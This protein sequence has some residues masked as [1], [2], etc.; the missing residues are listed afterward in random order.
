MQK[1]LLGSNLMSKHNDLSENESKGNWASLN[2]TNIFCFHWEDLIWG[3]NFSILLNKLSK[4]RIKFTLISDFSSLRIFYPSRVLA[5]SYKWLKWAQVINF[6]MVDNLTLQEW[7]NFSRNDTLGKIKRLFIRLIKFKF[8]VIN[9]WIF[10][11]NNFSSTS[12]FLWTFDSKMF[13]IHS[14]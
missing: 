1:F 14:H 13:E 10:N 9:I 8:A 12:F 7:G 11:K 2:R 6:W 4:Y 3:E 5:V